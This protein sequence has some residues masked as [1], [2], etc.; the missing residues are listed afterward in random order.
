MYNEQI[1]LEM[2]SRASMQIIMPMK[3]FFTVISTDDLTVRDWNYS[4]LVTFV[5]F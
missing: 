3:L 2:L 1:G 4:I 5:H